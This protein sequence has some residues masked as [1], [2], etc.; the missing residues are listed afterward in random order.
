MV[1]HGNPNKREYT[2]SIHDVEHFFVLSDCNCVAIDIDWI[3][4]KLKL[5][6]ALQITQWACELK[7]CYKSCLT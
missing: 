7:H 5:Q 1:G 6:L 3:Q 2:I 4:I